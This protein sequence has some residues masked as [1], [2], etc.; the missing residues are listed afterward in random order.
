MTT[1]LT[2]ILESTWERIRLLPPVAELR[3]RCHD[4]PSVR[5]FARSLQGQTL[6]VIAEIKRRS[7]SRGDLAPGLDPVEWAQAY[8]RGGAAAVS[9]LTEPSHFSGSNDDLVAVRNGVRLPVIRKDFTLHPAQVWEARS[10]GADAILLIVAALEDDTLAQLHETGLEAGMDVLVEVHS[11]A[12]AERALR[13]DPQLVGVNNRDLT[14]FEVDL[15][16]SEALADLLS[17]VPVTVGESGIFGATDAARM[18]ASGYDAVLVG[19]A[20]VRS[21]DPAS[22]IAELKVT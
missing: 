5:P 21:G 7:P 17:D 4:A 2:P 18:R 11:A 19:E 6:D 1:M 9:V 8:E 12:E 13:L 16:T 15:A 22:S 10:I 14:T 20:L 3:R